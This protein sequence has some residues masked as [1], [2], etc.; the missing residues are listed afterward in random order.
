MKS[1]GQQVFV[2]TGRKA[3][4]TRVAAL[5]ADGYDV[6]FA[7][8]ERDAEG[9][10]LMQALASKGMRSAFLLAGPQ[11]LEA[12]LCDGVLSRFYLTVTHELVGGE[13]F[14]SLIEGPR[15]T[16]AARLRLS[17]LYLDTSRPHGADQ[18]FAQFEPRPPAHDQ[19]HSSSA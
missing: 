15:T 10:G 13:H 3:S 16:G 4:E 17:S 18:F 8:A 5:R 2:V 14:H 7:G 11:L 19:S 1:H 12:T 9:A 6:L